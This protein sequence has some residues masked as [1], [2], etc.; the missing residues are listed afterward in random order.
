[1]R[2][3]N[4]AALGT[5]VRTF[6]RGML[7]CGFLSVPIPS[8]ADEVRA[9]ELFRIYV[10]YQMYTWCRDA[11]RANPQFGALGVSVSDSRLQKWTKGAE[12]ELA[13]GPDIEGQIWNEVSRRVNEKT[14]N[15]SMR[16][17]QFDMMGCLE[18]LY[19]VPDL[20]E[21]PYSYASDKPF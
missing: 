20:V 16:V 2:N 14:R 18:Y 1:M 13:L 5:H 6:V 10:S 7:V 21:Q 9:N 17:S 3:S 12:E 4:L 15:R 19:N 8:F 11:M